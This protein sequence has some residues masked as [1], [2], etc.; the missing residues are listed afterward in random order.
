MYYYNKYYYYHTRIRP[1]PHNTR[2]IAHTHTHLRR[3]L[4]SSHAA[5]HTCHAAASVVRYLR[6]ARPH[7]QRDAGHARFAEVGRTEEMTR[8]WDNG[9]GRPI[10]EA[11]KMSRESPARRSEGDVPLLAA[12]NSVCTIFVRVVGFVLQRPIGQ[13]L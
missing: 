7:A 4:H 9:F 10:G 12:A 3:T 2:A 5:A 8:G 6:E 11:A 13:L 1:S